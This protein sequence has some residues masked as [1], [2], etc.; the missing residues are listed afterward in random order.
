MTFL[1]GD[2]V[3]PDEYFS[4]DS[5]APWRPFARKAIVGAVT[6]YPKLSDLGHAF[7]TS[8]ASRMMKTKDGGDHLLRRPRQRALRP[9]HQHRGTLATRRSRAPQF[10]QMESSVVLRR[11]AEAVAHAPAAYRLFRQRIGRDTLGTASVDEV[12]IIAAS[13][14]SRR[15]HCWRLGY[16]LQ[17]R[18]VI[19][20]RPSTRTTLRGTPASSP[21]RWRPAVQNR[22][23]QVSSTVPYY[24]TRWHQSRI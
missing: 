14:K 13:T 4:V 9:P 15:V 5:F 24:T 21:W 1:A 19:P 23:Y 20:M 12:D 3:E 22:H 18:C 16:G 2:L 17:F 11:E 6:V 7:P 8:T 10:R